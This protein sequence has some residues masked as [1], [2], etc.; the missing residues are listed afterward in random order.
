METTSYIT[1]G[2]GYIA[3]LSAIIEQARH[4]AKGEDAADAAD[5]RR[6]IEE[7]QNEVLEDLNFNC[8]E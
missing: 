8:Y 6:G 1:K 3:L 5:A 4:D 2:T 7:W